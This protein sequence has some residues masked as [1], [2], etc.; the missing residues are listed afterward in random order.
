MSQVTSGM[1]R[2]LSLPAFYDFFQDLVGA[3]AARLRRIREVLKPFPGARILD[4]GCGTAEILHLLPDD[5]DYTG[6]D[7]CPAYVEA[8]R[9]RH[10]GRGRFTCEKTEAFHPDGADGNGPARDFDIAMAF[11][12]LHHLE[13]GEGRQ[14]FRSARKALK[15]GGRF[16]TIDPAF[17]PDQAPLARLI[18]SR[19]RGRNVRFPQAYAALGWDVFPEIG[20]S[21]WHNALRMP[22]DHA[23][24]ECHT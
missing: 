11:G 1:R 14:V 2:A 8:A 20:I 13:D 17:V 16:V 7:M 15:P 6:F 18:V 3:R 10:G 23:I 19:D 12:V 22:Y 24:L 21:T 5:I 9:R 4:I